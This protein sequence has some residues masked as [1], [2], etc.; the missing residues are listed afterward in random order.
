MG[1]GLETSP[2][3]PDETHIRETLPAVIEMGSE[4]WRKATNKATLC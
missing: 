1:A 2:P 4:R 3:G